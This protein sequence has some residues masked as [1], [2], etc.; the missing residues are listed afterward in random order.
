[1]TGPAEN[2]LSPSQ[3]EALATLVVASERNE[4]WAMV[5]GPVGSGKRELIEVFLQHLGDNVVSVVISGKDCTSALDLCRQIAR[6]LDLPEC[7]YKARF[8]IDLRAHIE[9]CRQQ[10]RSIL[11]LV[12]DAHLLGDE[13]LREIELLGN[14]DQY[15]PRALN[16]FLFAQPQILETLERMGATNLKHHLRRFRRLEPK[17]ASPP[18]AGERR[19]SSRAVSSIDYS[20]GTAWGP[21]APDGKPKGNGGHP[22]HLSEDELLRQAFGPSLQPK[23]L[24]VLN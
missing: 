19:G 2:S 13:L 12:K 5:V 8:L 14:N 10:G 4:G 20:W 9:T 1:V 23:T 16:I 17:Q 22:S 18:P 21:A 3:K 24:P 15:S 11:L 7:N 6:T